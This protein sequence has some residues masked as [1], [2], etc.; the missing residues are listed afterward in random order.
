MLGILAYRCCWKKT[1]YLHFCPFWAFDMVWKCCLLHCAQIS[2]SMDQK[3]RPKMTWKQFR[4]HWLTL[5]EPFLKNPFWC[6]IEPFSLKRLNIE[7]CTT[8]S[9]STWRTISWCKEPFKHARAKEPF[10]WSHSNGPVQMVLHA[11]SKIHVFPW[12]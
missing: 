12:K 2:Q 11:K 6:Y 3:Q 10:K 4:F 5:K 8:H 7:P 9:P 1:S